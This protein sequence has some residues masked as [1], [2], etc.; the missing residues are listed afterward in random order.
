[1]TRASSPSSPI[2]RQDDVRKDASGEGEGAERPLR[3]FSA[4]RLAA[5]S[6]G[7]F[8]IAM[9]VMAL[10]LTDAVEKDVPLFEL[11]LAIWPRLIAFAF[12]FLILALFWISQQY[13]LGPR[14]ERA[15]PPSSSLW[16]S[17]RHVF[18][19]L[20][21]LGCVASIPFPAAIVGTHPDDPWS[22]VIYGFVLTLAAI[23]LELTWFDRRDELPAEVG[24]A[25]THRLVVAVSSYAGSIALAFVYP[26]LGLVA[27]ALSH[28]SLALKPD[29]VPA[30]AP[31]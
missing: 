23:C 24:R 1:M 16:L 10:E 7:V 14:G 4:D 6:D 19:H 17:R 28:V 15:S 22:F 18:I 8:A 9:T 29:N 12:S 21:F 11:W 3:T 31:A 20:A 13:V 25:L 5:L 27:F 30:K 2:S 26:Y